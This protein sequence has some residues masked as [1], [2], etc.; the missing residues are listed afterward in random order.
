MPLFDLKRQVRE[1]EKIARENQSVLE[2]LQYLRTNEPDTFTGSLA[3]IAKRNRSTFDYLFQKLKLTKD[4]R[5]N[6]AIDLFGNG[7]ITGA[8]AKRIQDDL[9]SQLPKSLPPG[10]LVEL[11]VGLFE[12][13]IGKETPLRLEIKSGKELIWQ[14]SHMLYARARK[15]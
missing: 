8:E 11:L 10:D 12:I 7:M 14:H 1:A 6:L 4:E 15:G 13:R 3:I 9:E 5:W 2:R